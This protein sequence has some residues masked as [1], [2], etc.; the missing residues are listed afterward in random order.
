MVNVAITTRGRVALL[1]EDDLFSTSTTITT[2][3][4]ASKNTTQTS[5]GDSSAKMKPVEL[6]AGQARKYP[7][8]S[9]YTT[10]WN[11]M[12]EYIINDARAVKASVHQF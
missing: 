5:W 12:Q 2:V 4:L 6:V 3:K 11:I 8:P 10:I 1:F 9:D 7:L